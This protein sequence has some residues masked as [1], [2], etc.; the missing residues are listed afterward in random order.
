MEFAETGHRRDER[1]DLP[2][3]LMIVLHN[4]DVQLREVDGIDSFAHRCFFSLESRDEASLSEYVPIGAR[5][6]E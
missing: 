6:K 5:R 3:S 1:P 4:D 2:V